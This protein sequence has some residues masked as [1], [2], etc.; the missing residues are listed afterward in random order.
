MKARNGDNG[1][2]SRPRALSISAANIPPPQRL[3]NMAVLQCVLG[4]T[5]QRGAVSDL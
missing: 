2:H 5:L 4:L 3:I 1:F